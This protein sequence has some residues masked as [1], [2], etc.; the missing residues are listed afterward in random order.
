MLRRRL[1]G[2]LAGLGGGLEQI[3]QAGLAEAMKAGGPAHENPQ[4][5]PTPAMP[6]TGSGA[7]APASPD[8]AFPQPALDRYVVPARP[9]TLDIEGEPGNNMAMRAMR[10]RLSPDTMERRRI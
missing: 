3:G 7:S 5:L 8:E 6:L 10:R 4:E 1:Q 2:A 9:S